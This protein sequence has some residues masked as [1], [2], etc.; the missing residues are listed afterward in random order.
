MPEPIRI[1]EVSPR[2]GFQS[3][4]FSLHVA[5]RARFVRALVDAGVRDI[6]LTSF[7]NPRLLPQHEDA[8]ALCEELEP[9]RGTATFTA[10]TPNAR[11]VRRAL[12]QD[13]IGRVA[14]AI[15][16]SDEMTHHNIG[17]TIDETLADVAPA[18]EEARAAGVGTV[19]AIS[20]AFG[21]PFTGRVGAGDVSALVGRVLEFPVDT[22]E[23]ADTIGTGTPQMVRELGGRLIVDHP[24]R[25]VVWH[26]H[27]TMGMGVANV[28]AAAALGFSQFDAAVGAIGG[29]PFAP[30]GAGNVAT[31]E[32]LYALADSFELDAPV[33]L[34]AIAALGARV[35]DWAGSRSMSKI[36]LVE[37]Q[38]WARPFLANT[39]RV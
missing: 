15:G 29:C 39:V 26:F 20:G 24:E 18:L 23:I 3:L 16:V 1:H 12:G 28:M 19:A 5:E 38:S 36:A 30:G 35:R 27:D 34:S 8:E 13:L 22:I 4:P 2:D 9:L 6:E 31:E 14:F 32:I 25:E 37:S 33:D 11:G 21:D 17:M 7:V 10:F